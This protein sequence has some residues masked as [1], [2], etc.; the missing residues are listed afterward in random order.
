MPK[1]TW[2][3]NLVYTKQCCNHGCISR[4]MSAIYVGICRWISLVAAS[5]DP[6]VVTVIHMDC[7]SCPHLIYSCLTRKTTIMERQ[8]SLH[9]PCTAANVCPLT[10]PL[11]LALPLTRK[12]KDQYLPQKYLEIKLRPKIYINQH[13]S[14]FNTMCGA[15][16]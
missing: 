7:G 13:C 14:P 12:S 2:E 8:F 11:N 4:H 15:M 10:L 5:A 6:V 9:K 3:V 16:R 1:I